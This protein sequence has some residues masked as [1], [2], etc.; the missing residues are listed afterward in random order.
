VYIVYN[1]DSAAVRNPALIFR[2]SCSGFRTASLTMGPHTKV[3]HI[4]L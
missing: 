3:Y 4:P 1:Q 2:C